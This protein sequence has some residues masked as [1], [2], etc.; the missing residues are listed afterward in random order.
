[1]TRT[2][3]CRYFDE[4][5]EGMAMAP[6]PGDAG[7]NIYNSISQEAWLLWIKHQTM[8]IN[9]KKL[10]LMEPDTKA[11]LDEQREKFFNKEDA[12]KVEGYI[13]PEK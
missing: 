3:H 2:V 5:K 1:M 12:D 6:F 8:L 4:D 13:P 9:E 11:Y 10:N 7:E